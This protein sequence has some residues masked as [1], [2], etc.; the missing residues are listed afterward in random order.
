MPPPGPIAILVVH[1]IGAQQAGESAH[2]LL[3]GLARVDRNVEST[4]H[5]GAVT[6]YGQPVRIYEVYW[7]DLLSGASTRG[8]FDIKELQSLSWFPW[9]NHRCGNYPRGHYSFLKLAWWWIALPIFNFF[10]LFAYY[11]AGLMMTIATGGRSVR[12][13]TPARSPAGLSREESRGSVWAEARRA[14]ERTSGPGPMDVLL[15]EYVGDVFSYVNS[16]GRAF[17]RDTGD[18]PAPAAAE[19]VYE[20]IVQRFYDRLLKARA[21]GC[22]TIHVVAHSLGTVVAYHALT[23]LGF[24]PGARTDTDAI[25]SALA[26]VR[27]LYTIGSPLEKIRFFWPRLTPASAAFGTPAFQ[28]D[29][30]V[31]WFDP[32]AGTLKRFDE[33]GTVSNHRL[34]G[35]GFIRGHVVYEHSPVFLGVLARGLCGKD[36]SI[37]RTPREVWNDRLI[38]VGET[39]FAPAAA[40]LVLLLGM[41]L[42]VVGALLVPF[43]LSLVLRQFLPEPTWVYIQ[44]V[45]SLVFIG[46]MVLAFL[47]GPK[48]RASK[49]HRLHWIAAGSPRHD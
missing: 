14:A 33:W 44:N 7:A 35:G 1:G 39:L 19:H 5:E 31:S 23:G 30:F 21:D 24:D 40:T 4:A 38:L 17:Y 2:K 18:T 15:D 48:V 37:A 22:E 16:A 3:A 42:F 27:R 9:L 49:V 47:V 13:E 26:K 8:A 12:T 10:A 11:G 41:S 32:V 20:R 6:V 25:R 34:L 43:L 45:T 29:N 28:W 46:A 36:V